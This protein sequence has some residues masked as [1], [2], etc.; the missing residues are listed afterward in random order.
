MKN[1][2]RWIY[3]SFKIDFLSFI[4]TKNIYAK[5]NYPQYPFPPSHC[6]SRLMILILLKSYNLLHRTSPSSTLNVFHVFITSLH[7][8]HLRVCVHPESFFFMLWF[9]ALFRTCI[10][11]L[12][13]PSEISSIYWV[14]CTQSMHAGLFYL[15]LKIFILILFSS[16]ALCQIYMCYNIYSIIYN[17]I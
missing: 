3:F 13:S 17:T 14:P 6:Y 5:R 10:N 4:I 11:L 16:Q 8:S 9:I 12:V 15:I 7:G 2:F 1:K